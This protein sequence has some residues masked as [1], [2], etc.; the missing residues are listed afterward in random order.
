MAE[1]WGDLVWAALQDLHNRLV[2]VLPSILAMLTL[3]AVGLVAAWVAALLLRRLARA[4]AFDQRA[5]TW[6]LV[7]AM[8]RAGLRRSPSQLLAVMVF[9]AIFVLFLTLAVD[10]LAIPGVGR[11]TD[12]VFAW[13]PRAIGAAVIFLV[14][15]LMANFLGEG[16]LIAAVNSGLPAAR[17]MA[18]AV[19]WGVLLFA[20]ATAVTHLGIGKEMVLVAFG[21]T[22]GGLILALALAFGLGGRVLARQILERRLRQEP[23][24]SETLTHL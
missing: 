19:R 11:V 13:V 2:A 15:W 21:L 7:S 8:G 17:L 4:V 12:F 5:E 16:V 1:T 24:P 23:H 9:W 10:A 6:G 18:R 14:G 22:F 20:S 3:A